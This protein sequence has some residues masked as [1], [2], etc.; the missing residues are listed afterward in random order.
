[1]ETYFSATNDTLTWKFY[2]GDDGRTV[3][4]QNL[5]LQNIVPAPDPVF[6]ENPALSAGEISPAD[7]WANSGADITVTRTITRGGQQLYPT[8]TTKTRYVPHGM[9]CQYG[10]GT[11]NP[12]ALAEQLGVCRP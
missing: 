10:P 11:D 8:D 4:W 7:W 1:M 2:S 6:E 12:E 3:D 5:G 9:V